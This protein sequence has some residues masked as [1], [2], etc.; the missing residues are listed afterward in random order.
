MCWR[1]SPLWLA[2][3]LGG[4]SLL[5]GSAAMTVAVISMASP[6]L[7]SS[8]DPFVQRFEASRI[9]ELWKVPAIG[10]CLGGLLMVQ[11]VARL[12]SLVK[13]RWPR[14][15]SPRIAIVILGVNLIL[16][17]AMMVPGINGMRAAMA[18]IAL[19]PG[20]ITNAQ[21]F[22]GLS[23]LLGMMSTSWAFIGTSTLWVWGRL[24]P[25]PARPAAT[26]GAPGVSLA[27]AS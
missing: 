17:V 24:L 3:V 14:P 10:L 18:S 16:Y 25:E 8:P 5:L 19:S 12:P 26:A 7:V 11:V 21:A 20:P 1:N 22:P 13:Q 9:A 4:F 15:A 2:A 6:P 27:Q 23:L